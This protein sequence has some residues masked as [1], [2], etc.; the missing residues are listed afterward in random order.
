[1]TTSRGFSGEVH[2]IVLSKLKLPMEGQKDTFTRRV[3][4]GV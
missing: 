3:E 4:R 2:P 1:M